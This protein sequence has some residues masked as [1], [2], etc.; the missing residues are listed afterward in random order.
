MEAQLATDA[1]ESRKSRIEEL[2]KTRKDISNF[3][4]LKSQ[5]LLLL[6][7]CRAVPVDYVLDFSRYT[8]FTLGAPEGWTPGMPLIGAHPPA[9][10]PDQMRD[11]VLQ[12]YNQ[13]RPIIIAPHETVVMKEMRDIVKS[14]PLQKKSIQKDSNSAKE[15]NPTNRE[16]ST[17]LPER[18]VAEKVEVIHEKPN[19]IRSSEAKAV[20]DHQPHKRARQINISFG[21]S[22]S[23]SSDD[24]GIQFTRLQGASYHACYLQTTS[25]SITYP[26]RNK[27][28]TISEVQYF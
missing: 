7:E 13:R 4:R 22:D 6:K 20:T 15:E 9:P 11:G 1:I 3:L 16:A 14:E 12:R 21:L 17:I 10:Q 2:L 5:E 18:K 24:E 8:T 26:C 27:V 23:E 19:A 28:A 25:T